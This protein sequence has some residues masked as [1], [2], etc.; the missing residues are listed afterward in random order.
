MA[1]LW[2]DGKSPE[3]L[4]GRIG[5]GYSCGFAAGYESGLITAVLKP[6]WAVGWYQRLRQ[7][8]LA[9]NHT[10]EDL[11]DWE[12]QADGTARAIPIGFSE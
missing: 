10:A 12:R 7:Y 8:Y 9:N 5:D 4:D 1:P 3:D 6:E 11:V 2:H